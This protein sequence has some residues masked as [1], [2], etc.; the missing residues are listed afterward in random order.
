MLSSTG[1]VSVLLG[2]LKLIYET[3]TIRIKFK[4]KIQLA[5]KNIGDRIRVSYK[6]RS[7]DGNFEWANSSP[8]EIYMIEK[9]YINNIITLETDDLKGI[10]SD[11]GFW[12]DDTAFFSSDLGSGAMLVWDSSWSEAQKSYAVEYAGYW[13]NDDGFADATDPESLRISKW[14]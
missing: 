5:N 6:R 8:V 10:G 13:T 7:A 11:V 9:D 14:W 1:G 3:E 4:T 2:R 12:T